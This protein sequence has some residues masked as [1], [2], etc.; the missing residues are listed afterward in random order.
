MKNAIN[1]L[2]GFFLVLSLGSVNA[3]FIVLD[4]S[5][6]FTDAVEFGVTISRPGISF[7]VPGTG[8]AVGTNFVFAC[9][10]SDI[11]NLLDV[12]TQLGSGPIN[13]TGCS[14]Q[15]RTIILNDLL[16]T[17]VAFPS[18]NLYDIDFLSWDLDVG[19]CLDAD[20]GV[21]C[22]RAGGATSYNRVAAVPEPGTFALLGI[23]LA[24]LGFARG[25]KLH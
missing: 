13:L 12:S 2:L 23:A 21:S 9:G 7:T 3:T 4:A 17:G 10:T 11:A 25:R 8:P 16:F 18:G 1:A 24:G 19:G 6:S 22:Q 15:P 14:T 20:G 5:N